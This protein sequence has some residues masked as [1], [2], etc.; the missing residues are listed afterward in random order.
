[1]NNP[2]V[3]TA[4]EYKR[5]I[6]LLRSY[7]AQ[8]TLFLSTMTDQPI[9]RCREFVIR[10]IKPEGQFPVKDPAVLSVRQTPLLTES[11]QRRRSCRM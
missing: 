5:D 6:N 3:L 7:V 8:N 4:D 9:E 11:W 2:F 10:Q 1:M